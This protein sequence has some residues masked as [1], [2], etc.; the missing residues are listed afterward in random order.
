MASLKAL[1]VSVKEGAEATGQSVVSFT[2]TPVYKMGRPELEQLYKTYANLWRNQQALKLAELVEKKAEAAALNEVC[3]RC[4][5]TG[6]FQFDNGRTG[7][8]YRCVGKRHQ[9]SDDVARN[10]CYDRHNA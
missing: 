6:K 4:A 9:T 8:C 5:G 2:P 7:I 10:A 3:P 1:R